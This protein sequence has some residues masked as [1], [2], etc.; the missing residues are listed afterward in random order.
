MIFNPKLFSFS[1]V[2]LFFFG[3]ILGEWYCWH[4]L[5]HGLGHW[6]FCAPSTCEVSNVSFA[7]EGVSLPGGEQRKY[8][9]MTKY[10]KIRFCLFY[11][12]LGFHSA[13][14][15]GQ[16]ESWYWFVCPSVC[17]CVCLS[18]RPPTLDSKLKHNSKV[19]RYS[20]VT[21]NY[22]WIMDVRWW[23]WRW[24]WRSRSR[25]RSRSRCK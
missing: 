16:A 9:I 20:K 6:A 21:H 25:S 10:P 15:L 13:R 12:L 19:T 7:V 5:T 24:S 14:P 23:R 1:L 2:N 18:V 3:G 8:Q 4:M 22:Y 11:I 17:M